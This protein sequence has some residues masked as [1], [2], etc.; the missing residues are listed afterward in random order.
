MRALDLLINGKDISPHV[1]G[2]CSVQEYRTRWTLHTALKPNPETSSELQS[3]I[4]KTVS[5]RFRLRPRSESNEQVLSPWRSGRAD[6]NWRRTESGGEELILNGVGALSRN[7]RTDRHMDS[8]LDVN[9]TRVTTVGGRV[10]HS[11]QLEGKMRFVS[12][13]EELRSIRQSRL[14]MEDDA[15]IRRVTNPAFVLFL[16]N[17]ARSAYRLL[18]DAGMSRDNGEWLYASLIFLPLAIEYDMKYLLY[19]QTGNFEGKFQDTQVTEII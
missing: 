3:L 10:V 19:K 6:L 18:Y 4:D 17:S 14:Q 2:W 13:S 16:A 7:N 12:E 15:A 11:E 8:P 1:G 5:I 9:A